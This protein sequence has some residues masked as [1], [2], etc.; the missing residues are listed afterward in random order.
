MSGGGTG[1]AGVSAE[2]WPACPDVQTGG[3][4]KRPPL[5]EG[6]WW[7]QEDGI[8]WSAQRP[9]AVRKRDPHSRLV[10]PGGKE[11]RSRRAMHGSPT[12]GEPPEQQRP[13]GWLDTTTNPMPDYAPQHWRASATSETW[14]F[15]PPRSA[16]NATGR[17]MHSSPAGLRIT[18]EEPQ[19]PSWRQTLSPDS[20]TGYTGPPTVRPKYTKP[21]DLCAYL[22]PARRASVNAGLPFFRHAAGCFG[23]PCSRPYTVSVSWE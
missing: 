16:Q 19:P 17:D 18:E 2:P 11:R 13:G 9:K 20:P 21:L 15:N 7:F 5:A 23:W 10:P 12:S 14:F 1:A 3:G 6:L 4:G 8:C 22:V